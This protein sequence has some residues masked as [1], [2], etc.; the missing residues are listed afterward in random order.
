MKFLSEG[1]KRHMGHNT[2]IIWLIM[3]YLM[4]LG[5]QLKVICIKYAKNSL[6]FIRT[7]AA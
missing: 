6:F 7:K 5:A 1:I 3:V 2:F 4:I